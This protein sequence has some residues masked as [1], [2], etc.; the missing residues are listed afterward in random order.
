[1]GGGSLSCARDDQSGRVCAI[2]PETFWRRAGAVSKV[3]RADGSDE[4]RH[5]LSIELGSPRATL[6]VFMN[7]MSLLLAGAATA[8]FAAAAGARADDSRTT[9][10]EVVVTA[11]KTTTNLQ[12]TPLAI[13]ALSGRLLDQAQIVGPK[14]LDNIVPGLVVNTTPSNPLAITIRGAGYEGIEN[15]SAQPG[16]S[17]TQNG[18]YIASPISLNANF[19]DVDT[20]EVL[21]GP[22]GTV[23]GQNSDGGAI[24][25]RTV[26]PQLGI[27][28]GYAD[29]SYGSY[30]YDRVRAV[31]NIPL[32]DTVALRVAVQ[33]ERHDGWS[34]A[35]KVPG[36]NGAYPLSNE[37]SF[38]ARVDL[39]WKPTDKLTFELW[40]EHYSNNTNGDAYKN[41]LDPDPDPRRVTQ[42]FPSKMRQRADNVAV[43]AAYDFGFATAKFIGS[44]QQGKLDGS[45][46]L[47]KLDYATA[48]P[49]LGVHDIDVVNN[50]DG[51]SY[52]AEVD[53][54][55]KPGT[56][57]DYVVGAF[58]LQQRY[59]EAVEEYQ[60]NNDAANQA[61]Y[62][63]YQ[64][65]LLNP[66][67]FA[68]VTFYAPYGLP[69]N[70]STTNPYLIETENFTGP[71]A[72]ETRD[73]QKLE[74]WSAYAQGTY[75]L[76][77]RIRLT[78]GGRYTSDN[79]IGVIQDYFGLLDR[80][81]GVPFAVLK[82]K[83]HK[84]TGR[85]EGEF[86]ITPLNTVYAM[87]SNG[88]K[89]GGANLNPGAVVIP[90][91]FAPERVDAFEIGSKNEFFAKTLR[92]NVSAF[93]NKIHDYQVDS[94]DPLP[95]QGGLT[96]VKS[97]HVYGV[98]AEL[99]QLLPY[100]LRF[101]GNATVQ[102]SKV[103]SHQQLLDP[104]VAEAIDIAAGGPFN[105]NDVNNRFA[106]FYMP[107]GDVYGHKLPKVPPFTLNLGL[108]HTLNFSDGG[109]LTSSLHFTYRSPY[110]FRIYNSP[111]TDKVPSQ[112]QFDLNVSYRAKGGRWH[113]DLVVVNLT[114]SDS[115]N[116]RY[117]DNFGTFITANYYVP[118]R[119][120][121]GRI[122]YSF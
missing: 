20:V 106:A 109:S 56:K 34:E 8:V 107:S 84:F 29:G 111:T 119:Q 48:L 38:N 26:R 115:V 116:S 82:T 102:T 17:Y 97:A 53:L 19:L 30:N 92:I 46:D 101:D 15:T 54:V 13:T 33:Q 71:V 5:T 80:N 47:D 55:S 49:I 42:D 112:N 66:V 78:L 32:G 94:E 100:N 76:T 83:F 18:V 39:L 79:Q 91:V 64:A 72:F 90:L 81:N 103:D 58:Y 3:R 40:A 114:N 27:F 12:K 65:Y 86:D 9:I 35:T 63:Q 73:T 98:E 59:N 62:A 110:F 44:Y 75:H 16:V 77:D 6:G 120:F 31:G 69:V 7:R 96:N 4:D 87:V 117:T 28:S 51:H 85:A 113:A 74:S 25:V 45:E 2:N 68:P 89:P 70:L 50:R 88:I 61:L 52:T 1:M 99:T 36:T 37:D 22:Q 11:Q 60:Y 122:G 21:R 67:G 23:L 108:Q 105:G 24:N 93:Y 95:F 118:P 10:E 14:D 104:A 57:L 43:N 41:I 121:I